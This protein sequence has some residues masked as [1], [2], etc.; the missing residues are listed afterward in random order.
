MISRFAERGFLHT[1][2]LLAFLRQK[3]YN[4]K[5]DVLFCHFIWVNLHREMEISVKNKLES[6]FF[7]R[8]FVPERHK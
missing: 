8:L 1:E 4:V 3:K 5:D 7:A 6:L 2:V